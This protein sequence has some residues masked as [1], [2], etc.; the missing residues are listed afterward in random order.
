MLFIL[1]T[2][3]Q[4][5]IDLKGLPLIHSYESIQDLNRNIEKHERG[6]DLVISVS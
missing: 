4:T 2:T 6:H 3:W 5:F 1:F